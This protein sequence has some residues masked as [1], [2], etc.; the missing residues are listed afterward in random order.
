MTNPEWSRANL[1]D[2][3]EIETR[4]DRSLLH[5]LFKRTRFQAV[6]R[7]YAEGERVAVFGE[8]LE[9][10]YGRTREEAERCV[11]QAICDQKAAH[12]EWARSRSIKAFSGEGICP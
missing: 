1:A 4:D 9:R 12:L 6:A 3:W 10:Y 2:H 5:C 8:F 7:G 11:R